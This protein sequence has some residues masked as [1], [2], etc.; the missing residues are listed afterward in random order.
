MV[1]IC[2]KV[3]HLQ[4]KKVVPIL[5]KNERELCGLIKTILQGYKLLTVNM[6]LN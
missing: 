4:K 5:Y 1:N 6:I 2:I 3:I